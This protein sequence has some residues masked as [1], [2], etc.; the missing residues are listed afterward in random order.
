MRPDVVCRL[1]AEPERLRVFSA[2]VLGAQSPAAVAAATGLPTRTVMAALRRLDQGGLVGSAGGT[3]VAT[4]A[5]FKDALREHATPEAPAEP[6]HPERQRDAVL[7][8][9]I[10]DGRIP[11]LPSAW[12]KRVY[13]CTWSATAPSSGDS[14]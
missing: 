13:P 8:A 3:L 14:G 10:V 1:L 4:A 5:A 2:V 11:H 6:L 12:A 9:F 7:R